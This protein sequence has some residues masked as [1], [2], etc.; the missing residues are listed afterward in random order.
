MNPAKKI[1]FT[2]THNFMGTL[3][4]FPWFVL[5]CI[6]VFL[7]FVYLPVSAPGD[8]IQKALQR[9]GYSQSQRE[10]IRR[11]IIDA[12]KDGIPQELLL[13]RLEEGI[14][15]KVPGERMLEVLR[16]D[17]L[18][19][20]EAREI[21][22]EIDGGW[23]LIEDRGSWARTANLLAGGTS[24]LEVKQIAASCRNRWKD[25]RGA[26]YLFVSLV[27]WGLSRESSLKL[28]IAL[29]Q[30]SIMG[31]DFPGIMDLLV[32]GR[33][34]RLQPEIVAERI[35]NALSRAKTLEELKENVLYR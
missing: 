14:A 20:Q 24:P 9:S 17:S 28:T 23:A 34:L 4:G 27:Q 1:T 13:P 30:S 29:L 22:M 6:I 10:A 25:Y 3:T 26:T 18:R 8:T 31:K 21:L 19:L 11:V 32:E 2:I 35:T 33:R 12:E 15:K 7:V 5:R 16:N